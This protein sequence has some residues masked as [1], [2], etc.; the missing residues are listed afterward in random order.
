MTASQWS[1][2]GPGHNSLQRRWRKPVCF[3]WPLFI[4]H[5]GIA[6]SKLACGHRARITHPDI[7]AAHEG[8][9]HR[10][11]VCNA[12]AV[13]MARVLNNITW[14]P[15]LDASHVSPVAGPTNVVVYREA[16]VQDEQVCTPIILRIIP[17]TGGQ[18]SSHCTSIQKQASSM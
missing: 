12:C 17:K 7:Y 11:H 4:L 10:S 13:Q 6:S 1:A 14:Q 18:C 2:N 3:G 16:L 9:M 5:Y 8:Y 15:L